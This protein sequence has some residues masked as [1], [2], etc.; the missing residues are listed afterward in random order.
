[1]S[2]QE[3]KYPVTVVLRSYNDAR[4][5]PLTLRSLDAQRGVDITLFVF[6]SAS[7]DAS[8]EILERHGYD[9]IEHLA[10]G[11]YH[12]ATVLNKGTEWAA[13]EFVA[14]VN[15][16]AILLSDDVLLKLARALNEHPRCG[17]AFA[18]QRPR[19]DASV[20]TRLDY[21]TAFDHRE[22]L[23]ESFDN[24]SLVTSMI[25]RSCWEENPFDPALTYAEDHVWSERAKAAGWTLRY[26]KDAEVEH[27]H[28]YTSKEMYRRSYG[29]AAAI[30]MT[31]RDPP[32]RDPLRGVVIPLAKRMVRDVGRLHQMGEL[33]SAL[34][35]PGYRLAAQLGQWFGARDGWAQAGNTKQP[36]VP[37]Q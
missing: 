14:Y 21:Y 13:T 31:S 35:L 24:L 27:S 19:D 3:Q 36:T 12:S 9:R 15:S 5:L 16:D 10:P 18:R 2:T 26:V 17:G 4:L 22:Q 29:D 7:T 30:G 6:E 11:S 20:M 1:M 34:R 37:R 8:P 25:R 33:S 32:P 23:G 28:N